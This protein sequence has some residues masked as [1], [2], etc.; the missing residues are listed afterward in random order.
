MVMSTYNLN[1]RKWGSEDPWD[2]LAS[3]FGLIC[4]LWANEKPCFKV[5][6]WL[7]LNMT[8]R[9]VIHPLHTCAH[10]CTELFAFLFW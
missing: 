2:S 6:G 10:T 7:F 5:G 3:R 4:E 8:P 9:V 1:W